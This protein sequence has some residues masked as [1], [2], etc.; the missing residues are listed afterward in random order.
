M[1]K[2]AI[3]IIFI[4]LTANLFPSIAKA[5]TKVFSK[6]TNSDTYN[7]P[8]LNPKYDI[9]KIEV[10]LWDSDLDMIHFWLLF[11]QPLTSRLLGRN[12]D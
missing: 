9:E 12:S 11:K 7:R 6:V 5:E 2:F 10:G 3:T 8:D 4:I 1:K